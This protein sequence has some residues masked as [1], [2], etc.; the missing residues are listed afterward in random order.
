MTIK[1][2]FNLLVTL[3]QYLEDA[4]IS[5]INIPAFSK[6]IFKDLA[7]GLNRSLQVHM[8]KK[9]RN[10]PKCRCSNSTVFTPYITV[11]GAR[12]WHPTS[13]FCIPLLLH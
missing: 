11:R 5:Y 9:R 7:I 4:F 8:A 6:K 3:V 2:W 1:F 12:I 10:T 13:V